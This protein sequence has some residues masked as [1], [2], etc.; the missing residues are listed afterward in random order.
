MV[1]KTWTIKARTWEYT[2]EQNEE[3]KWKCPCCGNFCLEEPDDEYACP[4]CG[5]LN[6]RLNL[7]GKV[8]WG[9]KMSLNEARAAWARGDPIE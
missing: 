1:V 3:G 6:T 7:D 9:Q 4:V 8:P 5:M 2:Y